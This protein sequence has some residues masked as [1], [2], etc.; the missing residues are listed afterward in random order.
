MVSSILEN[1]NSKYALYFLVLLII[2]KIV[3]LFLESNYNYDVLKAVSDYTITQANLEHIETKGHILSSIGLSLLVLPFAYLL[4]KKKIQ[5]ETNIFI[6]SLLVFSAVSF[7]FYNLLTFAMNKIVETNSDKRYESYYTGLL[8][9]GILSEKFGYEKFINENIDIK[10]DTTSTILISNMF[11]LSF[12][13][14]DVVNKVKEQGKDTIVDLYIE[15]YLDEQY[16]KDREEFI[17]KADQIKQAWEKYNDGKERINNESKKFTQKYD[18][19]EFINKMNQKYDNYT[20]AKIDFEKKRDLEYSKIDNYYDDLKKYFKNQGYSTAENRYSS[21]MQNIFEK[22]IEPKR[23][24]LDNI[25]PSKSKIKMVIDEELELKWNKEVNLPKTL[26][27]Q[28]E[29]L[30]HP[31]VKK[32]VISELRNNGLIVGDNFDYS[33]T[34]FNNAY[35]GRINKDQSKALDNFKKEFR[36]QIGIEN[37]SLNLNKTSF[38]KLFE[39]DFIKK[40]DSEKYGKKAIDLIVSGELNKFYDELYQPLYFDKYFKDIFYDRKDF[41]TNKLAQKRGD[42]FIKMLYIP[43]FALF[44]SLLAGIL[45]LLSVTVMIL[46]LPFESRKN[47]IL[48][49]SKF[50]I[51]ILLL[52]G[53]LSFVYFKGNEKAYINNNEVLNLIDFNEYPKIEYYVKS[54]NTIIY[55]EEINK[56]IQSE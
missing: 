19:S 6:L 8:K 18:Y 36:D 5:N 13:D 15:K 37:I 56:K 49:V 41:E 20:N 9:F 12:V 46:F 23:W 27:N 29:F 24:C 55:L 11:L 26:K 38:I 34:Q 10:N 45:N 35:N 43:P 2:S 28:K 25:C 31:K 7:I 17:S 50:T 14:K 22:Y 39:K 48:N 51:N 54:L 47:L 53:V 16:K 44:M 52:M 21:S 3:Y 1:K 40:F 32:E 30:T 42:D 33:Q 4:L